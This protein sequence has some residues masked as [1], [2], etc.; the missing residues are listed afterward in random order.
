[1]RRADLRTSRMIAR[2]GRA[3]GPVSSSPKM[4]K[5]E[6]YLY[7]LQL[8]GRRDYTIAGLRQ[9]L[10][11]KFGNVSEDLIEQ[12]LRKNFLNDRRFSENYV[13]KRKDRGGRMLRAE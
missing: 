12:L 5:N 2:N 8:L 13:A 4:P 6:V 3:M 9:K 1:M 11:V 10:L 7:A